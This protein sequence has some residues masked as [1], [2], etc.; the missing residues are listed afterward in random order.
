MSDPSIVVYTGVFQDYDVLVEPMHAPENVD[1]VCFTDDPATA[2]GIWEARTFD[3]AE[4]PRDQTARSKMLPH[5]YFAE[6]DYSVWIDG[7]LW[8]TG[9]VT[10]LIDESS[11]GIVARQHPRRDCI[12]DEAAVC[13]EKELANPEMVKAQ[14]TRYRTEGFPESY[15]LSDVAILVRRHS[16]PNVRAVMETWWEEFQ[17]GATRTQLSFEYALWTHGHDIARVDIDFDDSAYF[18]Q[19]SHKPPGLL[20]RIQEIRLRSLGRAART[21]D[22]ASRAPYLAAY[23][24]TSVPAYVRMSRYLLQTEGAGALTRAAI[25]KIAEVATGGRSVRP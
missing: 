18:Q 3:E 13:I 20:G 10:D 9:D 25:R 14:M 12:Y 8:L 19:F 2:T 23:A 1:F 7:N 16:D 6:Y 17:R 21:P 22:R 5:K 24:L 15:G 4:P 11:P